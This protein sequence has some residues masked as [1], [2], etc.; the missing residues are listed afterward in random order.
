MPAE[1][2]GKCIFGIFAVRQL[3]RPE[4]LQKT[5]VRI[6]FFSTFAASA[7]C[8]LTCELPTG[9]PDDLHQATTS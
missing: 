1:V 5:K 6:M 9:G 4:G 3:S 8:D 7:A 2:E